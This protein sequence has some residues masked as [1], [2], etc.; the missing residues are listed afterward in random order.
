VPDQAIPEA[1]EADT[2]EQT[3]EVA[4]DD[5][6]VDDEPPRLARRA[7]GGIPLEAPEA[8]VLEQSIEVPI[9]EDRR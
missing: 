8:D 2:Q 7:T 4:L 9:D 5:A 1:D 6:V 3:E